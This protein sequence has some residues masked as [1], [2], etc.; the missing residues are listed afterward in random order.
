M[1]SVTDFL[2]NF[3]SCYK[4][5]KPHGH[6]THG[7]PSYKSFYLTKDDKVFYI[8]VV[9][10][11]IGKDYLLRQTSNERSVKVKRITSA[12]YYAA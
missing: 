12:D 11:Y 1:L 7:W 4:V 5:T 6:F 2:N 9:I 10:T 8:S 3:L